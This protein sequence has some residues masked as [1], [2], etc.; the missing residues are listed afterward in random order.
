[1]FY[2]VDFSSGFTSSYL[3]LVGVALVLLVLLFPKGILGTVRARVAP[4]LP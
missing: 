3:L 1:M 4:W 2:L